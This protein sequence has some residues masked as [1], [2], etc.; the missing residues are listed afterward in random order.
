MAPLIRRSAAPSPRLRVERPAV[1]FRFVE[2]GVDELLDRRDGVGLVGTV[3]LDGDERAA[4]GGEEEDAEDRLAVDLLVALADLDVR[5]EARRHVDELRRRARMKAKL[6]LD[7][8]FALD[9]PLTPARR[10]P[11]AERRSEATRIAFAPFS[12][13]TCASVA[14]SC[15]S[16]AIEA[17]LTII[18]RFTPV[19]IS[20][21]SFSRNE[22]LR[23][24][25]VPPN[26]SVKMMTPCAVPRRSRAW[27]IFSRASSTESVHSSGTA[28][29]TPASDSILRAALSSS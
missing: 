7:L 23:L 4:A 28:S 3:G 15:A 20:T 22:R 2:L 9:Q 21:R 17:N 29:M 19:T 14:R 10:S 8:E 16:C 12:L 5:A 25:G 13:I 24:L 27:R 26:M 18:G 1:S 11:A 6:V